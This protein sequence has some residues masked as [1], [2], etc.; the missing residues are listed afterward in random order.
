MP[1]I[2]KEPI[3]DVI[4]KELLSRKEEIESELE[5]LFKTN[6]KITNWDIPENDDKKAAEVLI[7]MMQD[8]LNLIKADVDAGKYDYY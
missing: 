7:E 2:H 3:M 1:D 5:L 8:K 4:L 6:M